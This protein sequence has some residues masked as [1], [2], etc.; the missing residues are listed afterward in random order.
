MTAK[1]LEFKKPSKVISKPENREIFEM[2]ARSILKTLDL[3]DNYTYGHS[4]RVAQN[5]LVLGYHLGFSSEEIYEL[6]LSALFHDIGKIGIPD[7]I[8]SKPHRLTEDEYEVMKRHPELS[9]EILK[10]FEGFESIAINTRHH[11]ERYDGKGYPDNLKAEE[12]PAFSRIILI[13]DTFDAITSSRVYRKGMDEKVAFQELEDFS[14]SQFDPFLVKHFIKAMKEHKANNSEKTY[15]TLVS[16]LEKLK[17][18]A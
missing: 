11:H 2:A 12:I 15:I 5:A 4:L 18:A 13:S 7:R 3:K 9:Y 16:D 14:G 8:L 1:K 6:E 10:D 17:E